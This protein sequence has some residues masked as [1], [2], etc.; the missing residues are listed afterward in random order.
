MVAIKSGTFSPPLSE[1]LI[2]LDYVVY[3]CKWRDVKILFSA[4]SLCVPSLH[5]RAR[6]HTFSAVYILHICSPFWIS[7]ESQTLDFLFCLILNWDN[8]SSPKYI[9]VLDEYPSSS[10]WICIIYIISSRQNFIAFNFSVHDL[11][12]KNMWWGYSY[13]APNREAF[14]FQTNA[15]SH[16]TWPYLT[17]WPKNGWYIWKMKPLEA[18]W[19]KK[20]SQFY[21]FFISWV[22]CQSFWSFWRSFNPF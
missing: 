14:S 15:F 12:S 22:R 9:F 1:N 13:S 19:L 8:I 11:I 3:L 21:N 6:V 17:L 4:Q 10:P 16:L 18:F 7:M 20:S 2:I 5:R